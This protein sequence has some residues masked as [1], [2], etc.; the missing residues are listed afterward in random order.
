[1]TSNK[2]VSVPDFFQFCLYDLAIIAHSLTSLPV[3]QVNAQLPI[4]TPDYIAPEVLT[5]MN[6]DGKTYGPECDWW[7]VGIIAYEMFYGKSPFTEGTSTK[8]FNNIMN[9]Q[10]L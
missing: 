8:T 1:M 7:S 4:G 5:V 6:G 2:I 9:F 3:P 10:V